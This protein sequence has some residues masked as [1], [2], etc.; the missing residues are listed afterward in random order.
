MELK[1]KSK[2]QKRTRKPH[3]KV[4][5]NF[6]H[7]DADGYANEK[8]T[9][10]ESEIEGLINLIMV[11][12]VCNNI[13]PSGR[14]GYDEHYH[15]PEYTATFSEYGDEYVEDQT[16]NDYEKA[17]YDE[18]SKKEIY[19]NHPN[20][21]GINSSFDGYGVV[22]VDENGDKADVKITFTE[23]EIKRLKEVNPNYS[24]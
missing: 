2:K 1:I 3:Y 7:G 5:V 10:R 17:I 8:I 15:I 19:I 20:Y 21:E 12:E 9:F 13:Y 6:M 24:K 18:Y 22:F 23:S 14:G 11:L 16:W 4:T